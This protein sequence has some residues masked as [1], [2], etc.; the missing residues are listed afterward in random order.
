MSTVGPAGRP[1]PAGPAGPLGP[2]RTI[3]SQKGVDPER[4]EARRN[5]AYGAI[6]AFL[7]FIFIPLIVW[8][9]GAITLAE[10]E[11]M[12]TI[13]ASVLAGIVGAIIGFYF[14]SE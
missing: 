1:G 2:S 14:R 3:S 6:G 8:A 5:I 13:I 4:E 11:K 12:I 7:L 10:A 9:V